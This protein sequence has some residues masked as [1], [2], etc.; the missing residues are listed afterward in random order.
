MRADQVWGWF[1]TL[2]HTLPYDAAV[3]GPGNAPHPE[4]LAGIAAPALAISGSLSPGWMTA[5]TRAVAESVPGA[6]HVVV[7]GQDH[8]VL[9][10]PESL[11]RLLLDFLS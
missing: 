1:T 11:R 4:R 8:G 7:E 5:G 2:A 9:S 6:R 3:C 10:H